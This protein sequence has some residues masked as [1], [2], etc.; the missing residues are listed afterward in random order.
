MIVGFDRPLFQ[1]EV[2]ASALDRAGRATQHI[3]K[4]SVSVPMLLKQHF[5]PRVFIGCPWVFPLDG[6]CLKVLLA[7]LG[8]PCRLL[9]QRQRLHFGKINERAVLFCPFPKLIEP[10]DTKTVLIDALCVNREATVL[11]PAFQL[12]VPTGIAAANGD[13]KLI[14]GY[15][16]AAEQNRAKP[17]PVFSHDDSLD[18][19]VKTLCNRGD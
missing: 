3:G 7:L 2:V 4:L 5:Q 14:H 9:A 12:I 18:G 17:Q 10:N 11:N 8:Y 16:V 15:V 6:K 19:A 13:Y 1:A